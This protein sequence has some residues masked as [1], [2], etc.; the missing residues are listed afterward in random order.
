MSRTAT[1]LSLTLSLTC[2]TLVGISGPALGQTGLDTAREIRELRETVD[3]LR[4]QLEVVPRLERQLAA[5][6]A[7][8]GDNWIT[9]Q[10][11]NEIRALVADVVADADSR[12]SL[13]QS[14]MT[15]GWNNGFILTA[16]DGSFRL[17]VGGQL[18]QRY[19]YNHQGDSPSDDNRSGFEVRR[20]RLLLSG[21]IID[22]TWQYDIQIAANRSGGDFMLE[23]AGWIQKDFGEGWKLRVGQFK[24]PFMREEMLSSIRMLAVERSLINSQFS[25]GNVQGAQVSWGDD[26]FRAYGMLHDGSGTANT[27]W[28]AEDTEYALTGRV[29]WLIDGEWGNFIDYHSFPDESSGLL[30]GAAVNYSVDEYGTTFAMGPPPRGNDMEV[31]NFGF[32][33]DAMVDFGGASI[34]GAIVYRN[35]QTDTGADFNLDQFGFY[36]RG[37][38]F[39]TDDVQIYAQYEWGDVDVSGIEDLSV[40]T[41]GATK[42]WAKHNL[43]WQ[44]DIGYGL[45]EVSSPW[46]SDGAGWRA[47]APDEDGQFVFRTQLQIV[48]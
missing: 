25:A 21:H 48:F 27:A 28:S 8:Q 1:A 34:G 15:G 47:D 6:R 26:S 14:S 33:V 18:Q 16:P 38:V 10:R 39:V 46:A 30:L 40:I 3:D 22:S 12:T 13:L 29:E 36:I 37:G 11:A 31:E 32:T 19:V 41:L 5:L 42:F 2:S 43:K 7:A 17:K 44:S 23:D 35:L 20:A 9:T 24:A 45:N 4:Q